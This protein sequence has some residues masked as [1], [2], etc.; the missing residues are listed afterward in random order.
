M[1]R[2]L[3]FLASLSLAFV[4]I[5]ASTTR[6]QPASGIR[7]SLEPE[8][9]RAGEMKVSFRYDERGRSDNNWST[10]F[11]VT[12]L[13]GLDPAAVTAPGARPVRFAVVR[14]AGR[15]DCAGQ[16]GGQYASG[17]CSFTADPAFLQ[18]L[19]SRGIARPTWEQSMGLMA[20]DVRRSLIDALAAARYPTP[21]I[22]D[23]MSL[24]ALGVDQA[25]IADLARVGY[26]PPSLDDLVQFKALS[27]TPDYVGSLLR[28]GYSNI[29]PD[30]LVQLKALGVTPDY[31]VGF[32]RLRYRNIPVDTLEQLKALDV[33]PEFVSAVRR[34]PGDLPPVSDLVNLKIFQK[35]R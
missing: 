28:I 34:N 17:D 22:D 31:I 14:E 21:K 29:A 24:A 3:V 15:I 27:I 12:A 18:L 7:F 6:A 33:T 30:D 35:Q 26:R 2:L 32:Q 16:G 20:L 11:P 13:N 8:R 9:S 25:Y 5:A 1:N 19:A 4:A 23:L 10:D